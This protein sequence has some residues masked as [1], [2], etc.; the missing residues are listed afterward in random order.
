MFSP[1]SSAAVGDLILDS[2]ITLKENTRNTTLLKEGYALSL[3]KIWIPENYL[4]KSLVFLTLYNN[5][6]VIQKFIVNGS[7][8]FFITPP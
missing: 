4:Y 1:L 3:D 6:N 5:G 8:F 7:E 2:T